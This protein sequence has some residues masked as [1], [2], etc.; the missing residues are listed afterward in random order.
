MKHIVWIA[1]L[2]LTLGA[3]SKEEQP[4]PAT[5]EA[6]VVEAPAPEVTTEAPAEEAAEEKLEVV[7]ESAAVEEP[8]DEP[9]VL[10]VADTSEAVSREWKYKE[11]QHYTRLVPA[12]TTFGGADKIEVSEAFMYSCPHCRTLDPYLN[13]WNTDN[14]PGIRFVRIPAP[15]NQAGILHAQIYYTQDILG[16]N[17]SLQDAAAFHQAVFTEFHDRGNRLLSKDA[18]ERLFARFGVSSDDFNKAWSSFEV[19]TKMRKGDDLIRRYGITSVPT[20][21]V[22]GKYRTSAAEAG[23]YDELI[24]LIDE[25]TVREGIR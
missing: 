1:A 24:E 23:G 6:A 9:I 12:Q 21:V 5:E 2:A 18:V 13:R 7:E 3:C 17:G 19:N 15:W 11:G 16:K 25:L 4:A 10:A 8:E 20:V 22:N 14:D